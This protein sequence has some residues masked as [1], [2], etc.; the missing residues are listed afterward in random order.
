MR[1]SHQLHRDHG[2]VR[3]C[4]ACEGKDE[5]ITQPNFNKAMVDI[6]SARTGQWLLWGGLRGGMS[7]ARMSA[8]C[9]VSPELA[10]EIRDQWRRTWPA[11]AEWA[12]GRKDEDSTMGEQSETAK[13]GEVKRE[14]TGQ[15]VVKDL[16]ST[17][18]FYMQGSDGIGWA[19][20]Q[21]TASR[22]ASAGLAMAAWKAGP[23]YGL[24]QGGVELTYN[25]RV[26]PKARPVALTRRVPV[27]AAPAA[28]AKTYYLHDT[29]G[30]AP[31]YF[32]AN[33]WKFTVP[34]TIGFPSVTQAWEGF[35]KWKGMGC[36][37]KPESVMRVLSHTPVPVNCRDSHVT[38]EQ[39]REAMVRAVDELRRR[40]FA[41]HCAPHGSVDLH[42]IRLRDDIRSGAFK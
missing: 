11:T 35:R 23:A 38:H 27:P 1:V 7:P 33:G 41:A 24:A 20:E 12:L 31:V 5:D 40:Y 14:R 16:C 39:M 18:E 37:S 6:W 34:K 4:D 29:V 17:G 10:Q 15:W 32:G 2:Y 30:T 3:G 9:A 26:H 22:F 25:E 21:R 28:P 36:S 13:A 8:A 42:V 19:R